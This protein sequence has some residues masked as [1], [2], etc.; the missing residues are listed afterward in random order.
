MAFSKRWMPAFSSPRVT[1]RSC[2]RDR[3]PGRGRRH[4]CRAPPVAQ[5][6]GACRWRADTRSSNSR[7]AHHAEAAGDAATVAA[8]APVAA[9]EAAGLGAHREA[10]RHYRSALDFTSGLDVGE[11]AQLFEKYA[12][13]LHLLGEV[14]EAIRAEEAALELRRRAGDRVA[15]G[16][17][18]RWISRLKY[19]SGD[20]VSADHFAREALSLLEAEEPGAELAMA[21]SNSASWRCWPSNRLKL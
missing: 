8:V 6:G 7:L 4:F 20:R 5:S 1:T 13:E 18:L 9:A 12:F 17:C 2:R 19:F 14:G 21:Y 11:R 16:N 10:A 15:E 3:A